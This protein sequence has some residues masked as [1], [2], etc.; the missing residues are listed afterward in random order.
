MLVKTVTNATLLPE[1]HVPRA[2]GQPLCF[3]NACVAQEKTSQCGKRSIWITE[4]KKNNMEMPIWD[5]QTQTA[6]EPESF[7]NKWGDSDE[8]QWRQT[9]GQ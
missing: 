5:L 4:K 2:M 8:W 3:W 9:K 1:L 6:H 7:E